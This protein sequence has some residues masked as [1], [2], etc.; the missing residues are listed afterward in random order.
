MNALYALINLSRLGELD[1]EFIGAIQADMAMALNELNNIH[2]VDF[3][4]FG[5]ED[6]QGT[7]VANIDFRDA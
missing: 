2:R 1:S 5:I 3:V 6:E 7:C 4:V